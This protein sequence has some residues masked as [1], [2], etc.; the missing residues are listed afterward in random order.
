MP[1]GGFSQGSQGWYPPPGMPPHGVPPQG[2]PYFPPPGGMF[3]QP[4]PPPH[5]SAAAHAPAPQPQQPQSSFSFPPGLIP[6]LVKSKGRYEAPYTALDPRDVE[7]AGLPAP[8]EKDAYLKSRL[9]RFYA[10][11]QVGRHCL[12][13][14]CQRSLMTVVLHAQQRLL[15][16]C[17]LGWIKDTTLCVAAMRYALLS[18]YSF[19]CPIL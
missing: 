8:P 13:V 1:A 5:P 6:Q 16:F 17:F 10:E 18:L 15:T 3:A 11:I 9:D 2:V 19:C 14:S 12:R 4:P 7:D